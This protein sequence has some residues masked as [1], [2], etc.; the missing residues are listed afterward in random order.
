MEGKKEIEDQ[1]EQPSE[2]YILYSLSYS[3]ARTVPNIQQV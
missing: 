3:K 1:K 2:Q